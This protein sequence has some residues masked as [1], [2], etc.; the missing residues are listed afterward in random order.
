VKLLAAATLFS[1]LLVS[2]CDRYDP[3]GVFVRTDCEQQRVELKRPFEGTD[4]AFAGSWIIGQVVC[5]APEATLVL[6]TQSGQV[7]PGS[8]TRHL[9]DRQLRLKPDEPLLPNSTYTARVDTD[10]GHRAWSFTTSATGSDVGIAL[11][12]IAAAADPSSGLLLDPIGFGPHLMA[13]LESMRPALQLLSDVESSSLL[14]R[15][16]AWTSSLDSGT[17]D[18]SR[19]TFDATLVWSDPYFESERFDVRWRLENLPLVLEDATIGGGVQPGPG[20]LEGFWLSGTWDTRDAQAALGDVCAADIDGGGDGCIPC[21]DGAEE[22][23]P[24]LLVHVPQSPWPGTLTQV[25]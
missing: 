25:D 22:C 14:G 7:V 1:T 13:E 5:V 24:F 2:G 19:S 21:R 16:G 6:K 20:S 18:G 4:Q 17:Q 8:L 11:T 15:L 9:D 10:D 23:L 3:D 12:G